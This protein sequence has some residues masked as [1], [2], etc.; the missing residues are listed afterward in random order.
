MGRHEALRTTFPSH[1]G[2]PFQQIE[3]AAAGRV[4]DWVSV[5]TPKDVEDTLA[6]G[7]DVRWMWPIRVRLLSVAPG[8]HILAVVT[9]HIASDGESVTPMLTDLVTAYMAESAGH[10]PAFTPLEVQYADV[11]L[12]QH[13]NL[14]SPDDADLGGGPPIG[15]LA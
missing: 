15:L 10:A 9:H 6:Q 5:D 1:E 2:A 13:Q 12:W 11:A 8:E 14:G 3:P 7:F 4:L